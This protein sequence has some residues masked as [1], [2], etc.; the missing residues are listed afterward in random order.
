MDEKRA[1]K[2]YVLLVDGVSRRHLTG[3]LAYT[4][5]ATTLAR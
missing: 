3:W 4:V 5:I 1:I 2:T